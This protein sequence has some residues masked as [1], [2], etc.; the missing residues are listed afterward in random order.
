MMDGWIH[1]SDAMYGWMDQ[2][3]KDQNKIN[4]FLKFVSGIINSFFL[5]YFCF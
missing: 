5:S 3:T 4:V 2:M 1:L